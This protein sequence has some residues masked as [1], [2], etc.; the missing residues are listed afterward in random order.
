MIIQENRDGQVLVADEPDDMCCCFS[1]LLT[2]VSSHAHRITH[3]Y[4]YRYTNTQ[5]HTNENTGK[6]SVRPHLVTVRAHVASS[7]AHLT[8]DH[9]AFKEQQLDHIFVWIDFSGL[10][11]PSQ[12]NSSLSLVQNTGCFFTLGLSLKVLRT[13]NLT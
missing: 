8:M 13:Q 4:K 1:I 2:V 12:S 6:Y 11:S 9:R 10:S 7:H 5:I 3:K